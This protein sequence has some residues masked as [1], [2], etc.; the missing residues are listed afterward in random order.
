[1][2]PRRLCWSWSRPDAGSK[3]SPSEARGIA[4]RCQGRYNKA[5][6]TIRLFPAQI[7]RRVFRLWWP[8]GRKADRERTPE[9]FERRAEAVA[10]R[11][12]KTKK[13]A[14]PTSDFDAFT[15]FSAHTIGHRLDCKARKIH[16]RNTI[17]LHAAPHSSKR[18]LHAQNSNVRSSRPPSP[19]PRLAA[20]HIRCP[21]RVPHRAHTHISHACTRMLHTSSSRY[22]LAPSTRFKAQRY[23][24]ARVRASARAPPA[25]L[26]CMRRR[27]ASLTA[28]T[29]GCWSEAMRRSEL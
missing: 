15:L 6:L 2:R 12:A 22:R 23:A 14:P 8:A 19:I 29:I 13:S 9:S 16:A 1:M 5:T 7:G 27:S 25:G 24:S 28:E 26:A 10:R 3:T 11:V 20:T 18:T 17:R 4:A 21:S